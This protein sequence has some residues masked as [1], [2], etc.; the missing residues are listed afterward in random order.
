[1]DA[2]LAWASEHGAE[3][4]A[5]T[6]AVGLRL[7]S[8]G[9]GRRRVEAVETAEGPIPCDVL[10]LAAGL[11]TPALAAQAGLEV[12]LKNSFGAVILTEPRP[13]LFQHTAVVQTAR[14]LDCRV[15]LRQL[16]D[17]AVMLHGLG[18]GEGSLGG[19]DAELALVM[20]T[21]ARFVP[22]LQAARVAEVR[23]DGRPVPRDGMP[24]LG[25]ARA[26]PNLYLATT[27]NAITLAPVVGELAAIEI[28]DGVEVD[29][30]AP[31]RVE[32]F[33]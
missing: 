15:S 29:L 27:H 30:L 12:P 17:G 19:T 22:S 4:R 10:V 20:E 6:P 7:T 11:G 9:D 28:L 25:F 33:S 5:H 14:D 26:V 8:A 2:S 21:A 3:V 24:V 31:Y 1:V 23:R 13:R 16:P 32:R 18:T